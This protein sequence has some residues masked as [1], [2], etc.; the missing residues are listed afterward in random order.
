ML[1]YVTLWWSVNP[2]LSHY[3][4]TILQNILTLIFA[5]MFDDTHLAVLNE[6]AGI[7]WKKYKRICP[8]I[9]IIIV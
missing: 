3:I 5:K 6:L 2:N 8:K 4:L 1:R 9:A 7:Q